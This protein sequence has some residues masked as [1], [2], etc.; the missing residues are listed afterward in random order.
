MS[1]HFKN[2]LAT[3][4]RSIK[5]GP[6]IRPMLHSRQ[7]TTSDLKKFTSYRVI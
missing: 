2:V 5:E 3:E 4:P 7:H 6:P 1:H